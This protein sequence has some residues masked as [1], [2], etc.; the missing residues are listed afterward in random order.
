M[1][2]MLLKILK[3]NAWLCYSHGFKYWLCQAEST[4]YF[5][6]T[7]GNILEL[8]IT[9]C[10]WVITFSVAAWQLNFTNAHLR[11]YSK[12]KSVISNYWMPLNIYVFSSSITIKFH[13]RAFKIVHAA[14]HFFLVAFK[15]GEAMFSGSHLSKP[16]S[17][18]RWDKQ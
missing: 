18:S 13:K 7:T 16:V 17:E 15:C 4:Y 1:F 9:G 11:L 3:I 5:L 2:G 14:T 10:F 12:K 8:A 6:F